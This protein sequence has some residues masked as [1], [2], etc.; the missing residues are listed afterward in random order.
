MKARSVWS[1]EVIAPVCQ[2][3]APQP[4]FP[5]QA[6]GHQRSKVSVV[7][8]AS[9]AAHHHSPAACPCYHGNGTCAHTNQPQV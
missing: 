6:Q 5:A 3:R 4:R 1:L 7:T 8:P 9:A 2:Q